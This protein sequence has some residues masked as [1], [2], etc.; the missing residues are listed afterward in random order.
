MSIATALNAA[1][2]LVD[3]PGLGIKGLPINRVAFEIFNIPVYWYGLLIA[4]SIILSLLL[5]MRQS[6]RYGF[7]ADDVMDVFIFMIPAMIVFARAYYVIFNWSYYR[8]DWTRIFNTREGGLAFYGGVIGALL[9]SFLVLRYKKL[10]IPAFVDFLIV[11]VPLAQA[12]GRWG[13]FFNQEA[14]GTNTNLPWGMTSSST[15]AYL[16]NVPG[17]DPLKPVHPTFLYEFL[18]N[19][20]IFVILLSLR[21]NRR[22]DWEVFLGYLFGYGL[23][24]FF[25]E[26]IRTDALMIG[27][28]SLRVSQL[29]SAAMVIGSAILLVVFSRRTRKARAALAA[30]HAGFVEIEKPAAPAATPAAPPESTQDDDVT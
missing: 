13:N 24:R 19:M 22:F 25:V 18:G 9:V 5:A 11:Y 12:I 29:L 1:P 6:D 28:T 17:V 30:S 15:V 2:V 10:S 16:M 8:A 20:I 4:S 3:F 27:Q 23:L 7:K 26:G 14:F 21:R